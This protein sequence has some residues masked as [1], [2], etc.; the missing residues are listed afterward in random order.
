MRAKSGHDADTAERLALEALGTPELVAGSAAENLKGDVLDGAASVV[1]QPWARLLRAGGESVF[2][3]RAHRGRR[4]CIS[5]RARGFRLEAQ[6]LAALMNWTDFA[7]GRLLSFPVGSP[8]R[9]G[10]EVDLPCGPVDGH[11]HV[12]CRCLDGFRLRSGRSAAGAGMLTSRRVALVIGRTAATTISG[13]LP[14]WPSPTAQIFLLHLVCADA[15][16]TH[17]IRFG[18]ATRDGG[19]ELRDAW[20][21]IRA[22]HPR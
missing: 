20:L 8:L 5:I 16:S 7:C 18:I 15:R 9:D 3:R 6:A 11:L 4:D 22:V 13:P 17:R 14:T 1:V 2:P 12:A 21:T 10:M 19:C